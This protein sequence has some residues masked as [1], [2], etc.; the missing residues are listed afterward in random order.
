MFSRWRCTRSSGDLDGL[1]LVGEGAIAVLIGGADDTPETNLV[2]SYMNL[3]RAFARLPSSAPSAHLLAPQPLVA[4][5]GRCSIP[6]RSL[7]ASNT[8]RSG[9]CRAR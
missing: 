1:D 8:L 3:A 6:A 2:F 9:G 5:A 4:N 7:Q